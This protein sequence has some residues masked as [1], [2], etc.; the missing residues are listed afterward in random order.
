MEVS[1]LFVRLTATVAYSGI[2]KTCMLQE[3]PQNHLTLCFFSGNFR[4]TNRELYSDY[5]EI[6]PWN[7]SYLKRYSLILF[8]RISLLLFSICSPLSVSPFHNR[9]LYFR[10]KRVSK[11]TWRFFSGTMPD[12]HQLLQGR[13]ILLCK[14]FFSFLFSCKVK[15]LILFHFLFKLSFCT[16][17]ND[18]NYATYTSRENYRPP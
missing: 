10:F 9:M 15:D 6:S 12:F 11:P 8:E 2:Q 14:I 17:L 4:G 18:I 5:S 1:H 13:P 3:Q 16:N 7:N